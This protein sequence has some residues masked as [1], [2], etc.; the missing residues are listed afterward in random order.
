MKC[1]RCGKE[2]D[3]STPEVTDPG[4]RHEIATNEWCAE[5]NQFTMTVLLRWASAYRVTHPQDPV[6]G[7]QHAN[8]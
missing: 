4:G 1:L 8:T 6:K 5:C 7:G 3:N 2:Y